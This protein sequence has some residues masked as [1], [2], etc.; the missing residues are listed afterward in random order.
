M[1]NELFISIAT[2]G[3]KR[4]TAKQQRATFLLFMRDFLKPVKCQINKN[5]TPHYL[6]SSRRLLNG[7]CFVTFITFH[8]GKSLGVFSGVFCIG[9]IFLKVKP[10]SDYKQ[11]RALREK[12]DVRSDVQF[13]LLQVGLEKPAT[14]RPAWE[15]VLHG[16]LFEIKDRHLKKEEGKKKNRQGG[17]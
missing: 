11:L 7:S 1:R 9:Y 15:L 6:Q 3:R 12:P 8:S 13:L 5:I 17:L 10:R 16:C 4:Q 14:S 2:K